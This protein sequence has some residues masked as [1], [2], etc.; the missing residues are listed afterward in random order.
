MN[1]R[2][3][4]K[5]EKEALLDYLISS[6]AYD[7]GMVAEEVKSVFNNWMENAPV[8]VFDNYATESPGYKGKVLVLLPINDIYPE[9]VEIYVWHNGNITRIKDRDDIRQIE[10]NNLLQGK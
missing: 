1:P 6:E 4:T 8:V 9:I 7:L 2:K 10:I 3:P 5:E